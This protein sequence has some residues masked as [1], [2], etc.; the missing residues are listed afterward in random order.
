MHGA[1]TMSIISKCSWCTRIQ[2]LNH[3]CTIENLFGAD[4]IPDVAVATIFAA[5]VHFIFTSK[6]DDLFYFTNFDS[7]GHGV[8]KKE[9]L[10]PITKNI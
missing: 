7:L 6:P 10:G 2:H 3:N 9:A 4:V 1:N 5:R 8:R